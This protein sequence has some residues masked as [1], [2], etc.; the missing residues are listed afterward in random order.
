MLLNAKYDCSYFNVSFYFVLKTYTQAVKHTRRLVAPSTVVGSIHN[1]INTA[2]GIDA[3][4]IIS[5]VEPNC[6]VRLN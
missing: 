2:V 6:F 1:K 4:H 5:L 3:M